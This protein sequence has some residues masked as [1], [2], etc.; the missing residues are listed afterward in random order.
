MNEYLRALADAMSEDDAPYAWIITKDHLLRPDD[1]PE[2]DAAG[3]IG[4]RRA[5]DELIARL[6]AGEGDIFRIYDDDQIL[7]YTGRG[8][9]QGDEWGESACF[10]PLDDFGTPNAGAVWIRWHGHPER[11][12]G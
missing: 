7:Y 4:P 6:K 1:D 11:D 3:T 9:S 8:L 5:T 10:G 2:D 12:N